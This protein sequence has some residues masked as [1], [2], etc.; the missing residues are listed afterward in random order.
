MSTESGKPISAAEARENFSDVINRAAYG[1]ER[2]LVTRRGKPVA[3]IV[4]AEDLALIEEIEEREDL[5]AVRAARKEIEREGT[6]D[7]SDLKVELNLE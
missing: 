4:P 1:H 3:A 5:A 2:I 7:W 6:V